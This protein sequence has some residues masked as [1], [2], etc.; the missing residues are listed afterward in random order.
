MLVSSN[1]TFGGE[2]FHS[3][4]ICVL[5]IFCWQSN[6]QINIFY[7]LI[8]FL[9]IFKCSLKLNISNSSLLL[10]RHSKTLWK[11][12]MYLPILN[13]LFLVFPVLPSSFPS[14]GS[15]WCVL[16]SLI[17]CISTEHW[18]KLKLYS[19][20]HNFSY[21]IHNITHYSLV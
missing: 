6:N 2:Y 7:E 21:K 10:Y 3:S 15:T 12:K 5:H 19:Q 9:I 16:L 18:K 17:V 1:A 11:F 13:L 14:L 4:L 20:R 8:F